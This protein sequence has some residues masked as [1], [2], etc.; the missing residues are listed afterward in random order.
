MLTYADSVDAWFTLQLFNM[1]KK[2]GAP[3]DDYAE[4]GQVFLLT[5]ADVCRMLTYAPDD[6]ARNWAELGVLDMQLTY[7]DV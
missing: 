6:Y 1:N 2:T 3:P 4:M 5:Y 7:A